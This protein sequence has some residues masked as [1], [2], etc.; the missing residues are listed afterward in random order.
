MSDPMKVE[1]PEIET[2]FKQDGYLKL[3]EREIRRR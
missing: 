3:H 1:V 2:L